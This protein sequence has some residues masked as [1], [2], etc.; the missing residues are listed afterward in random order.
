MKWWDEEVKEAIRLRR[1]AH[2]R[3]TATKTTAGWEAK[4]ILVA[5][6]KIKE[7]VKK[8]ILKDVPGS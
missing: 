8:G 5:R 1:E 2:A 6:K 3:Y 4:D 7:M